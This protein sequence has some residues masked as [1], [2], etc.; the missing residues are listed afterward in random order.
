MLLILE[1]EVLILFACLSIKSYRK[2]KLSDKI[3]MFFGKYKPNIAHITNDNMSYYLIEL[4][5]KKG[6]VDL[7]ILSSMIPHMSRNIL[8]PKSIDLSEEIKENKISE[9][10]AKLLPEKLALKA[11]L[12]ISDSSRIPLSRRILGLI[13]IE[14]KY[15]HFV[16]SMIKYVPTVK[17]LTNYPEKY[18][19]IR[20]HIMDTY[21]AP[22]IIDTD[23]NL[24]NGCQIIY[25]P[26]ICEFNKI[27]QI[28]VITAVDIDE[29]TNNGNYISY[30]NN[31]F[32]IDK[33]EIPEYLL[34]EIPEI[35]DELQFLD[36]VYTYCKCTE[37]ENLNISRFSTY[38]QTS[39]SSKDKKYIQNI[40]ESL[41]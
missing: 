4:I 33:L 13:D 16:E 38:T 6:K 39:S 17:V 37:L 11:V 24:L 30:Q 32:F 12:N 10:N 29:Y 9:H 28:P 3:K 34:E 8:I 7:K 36:A 20:E 40:I 1:T 22:L 35:Y 14:A 2:L 25:S 5:E 19:T 26:E 23:Y 31:I 21:G 27:K 41:W 18:D 15:T